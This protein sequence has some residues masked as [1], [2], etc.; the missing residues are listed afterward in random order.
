MGTKNTEGESANKAHE[1]ERN[2]SNISDASIPIE[3]MSN[4]FLQTCLK[5][6][7]RNF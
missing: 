2:T 6:K 4:K 5:N 1:T 3:P 7:N